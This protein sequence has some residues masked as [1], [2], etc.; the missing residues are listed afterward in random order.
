M[1][2]RRA[3]APY[4]K[5]LIVEND[6]IV[7]DGSLEGQLDQIR[8]RLASDQGEATATRATPPHHQEAQSR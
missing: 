7:L 8:R 5:A 1:K 2:R 3:A 6:G 4:A